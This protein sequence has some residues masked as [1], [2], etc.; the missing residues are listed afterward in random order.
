MRGTLQFCDLTIL[1][2]KAKEADPANWVEG[3]KY[4]YSKTT[5]NTS[6]R[7]HLMKYHR[8]LHDRL[9][10][11]NGWRPLPSQATSQVTSEAEALQVGQQDEFNADKFHRYLLNFIVVDDQVRHLCLF[12]IYCAH[13]SLFRMASL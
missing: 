11:E 10:P 7:P 12:Y 4:D 9:A 2:R 1:L 5:S 3:T 6:I 8:E 13:V